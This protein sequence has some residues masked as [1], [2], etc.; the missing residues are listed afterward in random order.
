MLLKTCAEIADLVA[1]IATPKTQE[2]R[3]KAPTAG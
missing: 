3:R 2:A 1:F